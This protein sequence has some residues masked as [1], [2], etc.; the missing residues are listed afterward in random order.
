ME[1]FVPGVILAQLYGV[2][3]GY[4]R[5]LARERRIRTW[6]ACLWTTFPWLL[7]AN[8][9]SSVALSLTQ[10]LQA[11]PS[12][13]A[14][15]GSRDPTTTRWHLRAR[16]FCAWIWPGEKA[17]RCGICFDISFAGFDSS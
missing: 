13:K 9:S 1:E 15:G 4:V 8:G 5:A 16:A 12:L 2:F 7:T 11:I 6:T 3:V 10:S 17:L 14:I